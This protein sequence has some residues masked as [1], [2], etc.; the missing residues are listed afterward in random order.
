METRWNA[1]RSARHFVAVGSGS[2]TFQTV[3]LVYSLSLILRVPFWA[4]KKKRTVSLF[5][6]DLADF[7]IAQVNLRQ[8]T[9]IQEN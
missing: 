6:F 7:L 3:F 9:W 1:S 5:C 8:S 2:Q 4:L